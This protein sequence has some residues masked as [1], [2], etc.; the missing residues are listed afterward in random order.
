MSREGLEP[1][2]PGLKAWVPDILYL[3]FPHLSNVIATISR[4]SVNLYNSLFTI[5]NGCIIGCIFIASFARRVAEVL[6][7]PIGYTAG[8]VGVSIMRHLPES[9]RSQKRGGDRIKMIK[10]KDLPLSNGLSVHGSQSI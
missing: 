9:G 8:P 1:S 10:R 4:C 3:V 7:G 2:T 6:D 5:I